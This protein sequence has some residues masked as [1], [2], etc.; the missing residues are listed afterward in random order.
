MLPV[1]IHVMKTKKHSDGYLNVL[2]PDRMTEILRFSETGGHPILVS[3]TTF[4][5]ML[6]TALLLE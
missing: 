1:S 2:M 6:S 3:S 4:D 5:S